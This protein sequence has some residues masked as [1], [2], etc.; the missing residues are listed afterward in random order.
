MNRTELLDAIAEASG[1]SVAD[2]RRVLDGLTEVITAAVARGEKI[3]LPGL[4]TIETV[5]RAARTGRNP[6]TGEPLQIAAKTAVK[7]TPVTALKN[8]ANQK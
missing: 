1:T 4:V 5:E 2:S 6:Q 8:A 3:Q 7:V